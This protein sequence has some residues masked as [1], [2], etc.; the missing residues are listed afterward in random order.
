[1][2]ILA[3]THKQF[4]QKSVE[5][6]PTVVAEAYGPLLIQISTIDTHYRAYQRPKSDIDLQRSIVG[7]GRQI[8]R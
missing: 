8:S 5:N 6:V 4:V 2:H 3:A 7:F 1:M